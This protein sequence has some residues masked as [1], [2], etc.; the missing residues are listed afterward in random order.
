[1]MPWCDPSYI[2][3]PLFTGNGSFVNGMPSLNVALV[4]ICQVQRTIAANLTPVI[5]MPQ[6]S[7]PSA[8]HSM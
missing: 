1:M 8:L 3:V 5:L 4:K 7:Y 2:Q 6:A